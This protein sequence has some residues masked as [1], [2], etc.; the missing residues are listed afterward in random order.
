MMTRRMKRYLSLLGI[1]ACPLIA[2]T[3]SCSGSDGQT[4][5]GKNVVIIIIDTLRADHLGLYGYGRETS[6]GLNA[7]AEDAIVVES[8][9]SNAPWTKPSMASMFTSLYPSQHGVV[10]EETSNRLAES[11]LTF[12][13]VFAEEGYQVVGFSENPHISKGRGFAQGFERLALKPGFQS[14]S[15]WVLSGAKKW[16]R[17]RAEGSPFLLYLHFLD[18]HGPYEPKDS[19][20]FLGNLQSQHK[21][22]QAG[23]VGK[24]VK[25]GRLTE[26]LSQADRDY[27]IAL[28]D[29]EVREITQDV[30][31]VFA[32]LKQHGLS[33]DTIV[34][35]T[36][37]HGEELFDH[38]SLKH[39]YWLFDEALHVPM[40]WRI[41]GFEARHVGGSSEQLVRHIDIAP[42]L[43]DLLG[44]D[45]QTHFQGRSVVP[46]LR[47]ESM[48]PVPHVAE[49]S[50]RG[51]NRQ[52]VREGKWKLIVDELSGGVQLFDLESDPSETMDLAAEQPDQVSRLRELLFRLTRM[53]AG[54]RVEGARGEVD[55][56]AEDALRAIGYLGEE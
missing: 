31:R 49:S 3:S 19:S 12:P 27:L 1:L 37:D 40:I 34:L 28:Y 43:F 4:A 30:S 50:W 8:S 10:E 36:S 15:E 56:E 29:A 13:E 39:G 11:L 48:P 17:A 46:L 35:L 52:A 26:E 20:D 45:A 18:P 9:L 38:G 55:V 6:A 14:D 53:P 41:P 33:D 47:G 23:L 25:D 21:L 16:M 5:R 42:T 51:I 44:F 22:V 54:V 2:L 24:L 7:F 32:M